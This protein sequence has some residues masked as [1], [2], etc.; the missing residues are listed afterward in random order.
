MSALVEREALAETRS[1][2]VERAAVLVTRRPA[3]SGRLVLCR[4]S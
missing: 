2:L 3:Q 4:H 1:A